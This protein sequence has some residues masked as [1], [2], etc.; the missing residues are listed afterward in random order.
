MGDEGSGYALGRE[1]LKAVATALEGGPPTRLSALIHDTH[2]IASRAD[3]IGKVY[4]EKW[5]LQEVAPLV[6]EAANQH[7]KIAQRILS[8]QTEIL[9]LH[10]QQMAKLYH[11]DL[12]LQIV[13][14]GG[15]SK[16]TLYVTHITNAIH[17]LLPASTVQSID[18]TP[19]EGALHQAS[20]YLV[21]IS[22]FEALLFLCLICHDVILSLSLRFITYF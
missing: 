22:C 15:L 9:A 14:M 12:E 20:V 3:L 21:R 16:S 7:D 6:L 4:Q 5:P 13:L 2:H 1:G 10:I 19:V 18:R 11:D 17:N 8:E